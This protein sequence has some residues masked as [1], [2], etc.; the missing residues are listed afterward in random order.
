MFNPLLDLP[1]LHACM[2]DKFYWISMH[3]AFIIMLV[4]CICICMGAIFTC[5]LVG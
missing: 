2:H 4:P 1:Q 5:D 3:S